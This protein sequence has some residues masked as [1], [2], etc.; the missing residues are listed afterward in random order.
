MYA[1][2]EELVE[3][4]VEHRAAINIDFGFDFDL[5]CNACRSGNKELE[6]D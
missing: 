5:L 2:V 6:E 3:Y 1:L 4:L